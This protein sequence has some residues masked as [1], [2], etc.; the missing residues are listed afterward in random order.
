M[1][2]MLRIL[3]ILLTTLIITLGISSCS[4]V[5][6]T[7][8]HKGKVENSS[9]K[10]A[11]L[12]KAQKKL[13]KEAESWL[14]TPY[15]YAKAE[16]GIGTDCSGFVLQIYLTTFEMKLPRTSAKQAEFCTPVKA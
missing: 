15:K 6:H 4:S 12:S 9:I 2:S 5:K 7:S 11:H 8:K 3:S 1:K 16:K 13:I 10:T 14:G